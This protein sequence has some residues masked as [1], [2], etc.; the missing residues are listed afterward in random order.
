[1]CPRLGVHTLA[2]RPVAAHTGWVTKR[3]FAHRLISP[4]IVVGALIAASALPL[5]ASA[6]SAPS[7]FT[8]SVNGTEVT[9][10]ELGSLATGGQPTPTDTMT[11]VA[12]TQQYGTTP[13][14]QVVLKRGLDAGTAI[15]DWH[16]AA[17][18]GDP[19]ARKDADLFATCAAG[20]S[21]ASVHYHLTNAWPSEIEVSGAK[22]GSTEEVIEDVT[23]TADQIEVVPAA[24]APTAT[25]APA[26]PR[27][28]Q[29]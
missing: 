8:L 13:P 22:A 23:L 1:M 19:S 24:P 26:P 7:V 4:G 20:I 9:F 2:A 3:F 5:N 29:D 12:H 18:S 10:Q 21:C 17:V 14:S 25:P 11:G 15:W 16:Q 6:Q 27:L 28:G